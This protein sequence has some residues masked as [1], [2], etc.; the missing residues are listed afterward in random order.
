MPILVQWDN[1][2]KSIVRLEFERG[3]DWDVLKQAIQQADD[4]ITSVSH[5]VHLI[6]DISKAGGLPRD[7]MTAAGDLFEQGEARANEGEKIVV[8]AGMLIRAAYAG[9]QAVYG[10]RLATRPFQFVGNLEEARN[11]VKALKVDV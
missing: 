8:G 4:L 2:E 1:P 3:W 7:F 6:I 11:L 9:F 5:T 10:Y